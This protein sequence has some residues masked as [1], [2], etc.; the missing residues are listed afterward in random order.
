MPG[1]PIAILTFTLLLALC[2]C[3]GKSEPPRASESKAAARPSLSTSRQSSLSCNDGGLATPDTSA[4]PLTID[5][6]VFERLGASESTFK[7]P[8]LDGF[9]FLKSPVYLPAGAAAITLETL[10]PE[11]AGLAWVPAAVWTAG[12]D[13]EISDY[14]AAKVTFQ[15]CPDKAVAYFG[16]LLLTKPALCTALR[17]GREG[18]SDVTISTAAGQIK[19]G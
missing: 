19:C 15:G 6:V 18:L 8:Q 7:L 5:G 10:N 4:K 13:F 3:T 9:Y 1:K 12:R 2:G 17:L 16:G 11:E 14:A